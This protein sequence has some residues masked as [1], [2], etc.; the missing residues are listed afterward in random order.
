[1]YQLGPILLSPDK[2]E[3][4]GYEGRNLGPI[5]GTLK[6]RAEMVFIAAPAVPGLL[7][8]DLASK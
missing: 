6:N 2:Q 7:S 4:R 3:I 8:W 5:V 1:M